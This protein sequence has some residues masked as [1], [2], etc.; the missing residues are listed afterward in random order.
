[1]NI[2]TYA[3]YVRNEADSRQHRR[4]I[5]VAAL[6]RQ[7]ADEGLAWGRSHTEREAAELLEQLTRVQPST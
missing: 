3:E 6:L 5:E 2:A 1:M 4:A 7:H